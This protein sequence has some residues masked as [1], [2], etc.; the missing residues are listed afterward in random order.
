MRQST[1]F[2]IVAKSASIRIRSWRE[3]GAPSAT[4]HCIHNPK[5]TQ[6]DAGNIEDTSTR[7]PLQAELY[8]WSRRGAG[9][10]KLVSQPRQ[11]PVMAFPILTE[12]YGTSSRGTHSQPMAHDAFSQLH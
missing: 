4:Q 11:F 1:S 2:L 7:D 9:N 10:L 6:G 12:Y 5:Q 8:L 3:S